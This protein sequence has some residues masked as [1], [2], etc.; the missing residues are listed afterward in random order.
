MPV[1]R[2]LAIRLARHGCAN[3]PFY[4]VVVMKKHLGR[5]K[6][7]IE[8]LGSYDPMPNENNELRV[9]INY[10][11]VKYWMTLGATITSPVAKLLGKDDL[12]D[13]SS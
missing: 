11:R 7:P 10:E 13:D 3:R 12:I 4:H 6:P 2:E 9:G 5:D 1:T 8:Q